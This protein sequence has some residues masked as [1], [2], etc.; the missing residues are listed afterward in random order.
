VSDPGQPTPVVEPA[1][2]VLP[3]APVDPRP[4]LKVGKAFAGGLVAAVVLK[5]LAKRKHRA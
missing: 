1:S 3:E 4:E 2:V 5:R